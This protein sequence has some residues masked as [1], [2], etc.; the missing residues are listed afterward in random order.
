M[1][2]FRRM[3]IAYFGGKD[4]SIYQYL[5]LLLFNLFSFKNYSLN[6]H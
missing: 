6:F 1:C 4:S 2:G 5:V 3:P